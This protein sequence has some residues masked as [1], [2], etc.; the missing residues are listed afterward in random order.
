MRCCPQCRKI[1]S[2]SA[3]H[4][5]DDGSVLSAANPLTGQFLSGQY[6]V[7]EKVG[8]GGS[9]EV[10]RGWQLGVER[11][12]ALKILTASAA[13]SPEFVARF[14][15]EAQAAA[16]LSHPHI[17][18]VFHIGHTTSALPFIAMAWVPGGPI[19]RG[20]AGPQ[21]GSYKS[22]VEVARQITSALVEAHGAGIIHRDL[23]PENLLVSTRRGRI[24]ATVVDFGI[25]KLLDEDMLKPGETHLTQLGT[26]YGTPQYLSPEQAAGK[27][28]RPGSDLYS[29]GVVL[30]ELVS[31]RLPFESNGVALLVDHL[32]GTPED[33][34]SL[35]PDAPPALCEL[36]MRLLAKNPE[37]RPRSASD[38]LRELD[39]LAAPPRLEMEPTRPSD[40]PPIA[41]PH[42]RA[43]SRGARIS[44]VAAALCLSLM[45]LGSGELASLASAAS[46]S[47]IATAADTPLAPL[48]GPQKALMVAA[49]G[50]ALRVLVPE[51]LRAHEDQPMAIE[52]WDPAGRPVALPSLVVRFADDKGN[53]EGVTVPAGNT[54]GR[55]LVRRRFSE[56]GAYSME[57]LTA[58]AEV[59]LRVH[60]D[61]DEAGGQPN[62]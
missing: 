50:Y 34:A 55:Y 41:N 57:V 61:V 32:Q 46:E 40:P 53:T 21:A 22:L 28:V 47:E 8:E 18:T 62:S 15:R 6:L 52:V 43:P 49:N 17:I 30:Y 26:V 51:T 4:C 54:L 19:G 38:L 11:P 60:F 5:P 25:A 58:D 24:F 48:R 36:V 56:S 7:L 37:A 44:L 2:D 45:A 12:V 31:G 39:E 29:L 23:K 42:Y 10:Y 3:A 35:V 13:S 59:E 16:H 27:R 20:E 1:L 14:V 33:L 9:A